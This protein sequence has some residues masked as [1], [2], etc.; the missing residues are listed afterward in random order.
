VPI[1]RELGEINDFCTP[2]SH[3]DGA[4]VNTERIL[5]SELK[6]VVESA[7]EISRGF[8]PPTGI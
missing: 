6:R 4:L 2:R 1:L 7:L 3:G 8:P 5:A